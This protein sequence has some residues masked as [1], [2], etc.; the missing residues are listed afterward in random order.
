MSSSLFSPVSI[1]LEADGLLNVSLSLFGLDINGITF[2]IELS[3]EK[4]VALN[5][6]RLSIAIE[7]HL[8]IPLIALIAS[9]VISTL[10]CCTCCDS[11]IIVNSYC[12]VLSNATFHVWSLNS[13]TIELRTG[14]VGS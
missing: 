3:I 7:D 12:L 14:W 5:I 6:A 13:F 4:T 1:F 10:S 8:I 2:I 9:P 11:A